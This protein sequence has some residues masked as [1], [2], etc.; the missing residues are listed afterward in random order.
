MSK[1]RKVKFQVETPRGI[2][3]VGEN[4]DVAED[5]SHPSFDRG[6]DEYD[7]FSDEPMDPE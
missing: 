2:V 3:T 7:G 6:S 1:Q 4:R 5:Y